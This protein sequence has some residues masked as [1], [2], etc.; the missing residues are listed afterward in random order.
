VVVHAFDTGDDA[1]SQVGFVVGRRVGGAVIRNRVRRRLRAMVRER[2]GQL[3]PGLVVV[4]RATASAADSCDMADDLG[5]AWDAALRA[6][7]R[8]G[9]SGAKGGFGRH[10]AGDEHESV[11]AGLG[12]ESRPTGVL[13]ADVVSVGGVAA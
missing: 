7:D 1:P 11:E 8:K 2:L 9:P 5:Q 6:L 13:K 12:G 10:S 4:V 3:R